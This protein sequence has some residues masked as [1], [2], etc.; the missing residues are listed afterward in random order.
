MTQHNAHMT[1]RIVIRMNWRHNYD[2]IDIIDIIETHS[3][4]KFPV[5][6]ALAPLSRNGARQTTI[7]FDQFLIV[8]FLLFFICKPP[9]YNALQ[10]ARTLETDSGCFSSDTTFSKNP[11][12]TEISGFEFI[13]TEI[14]GIFLFELSGLNK[15]RSD[16]ENVKQTGF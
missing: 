12:R 11:I 1:S 2:I 9:K 7:I 13:R 15:N 4:R 10:M 8:L 3:T 14:S 6:V 16:S 5:I